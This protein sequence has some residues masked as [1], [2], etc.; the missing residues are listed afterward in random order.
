[1]NDNRLVIDIAYNLHDE[2]DRSLWREIGPMVI[3]VARKAI[4]EECL[5]A[6]TNPEWQEYQMLVLKQEDRLP[7]EYERDTADALLVRRRRA[8]L[9]PQEPTAQ[10]ISVSSDGFGRWRVF[11]DGECQV[12]SA[13]K[14]TC[15]IY[16]DGLRYR[17]QKEAAAPL[18]QDRVEAILAKT[19]PMWDVVEARQRLAAEIVA[20]LA[21]RREA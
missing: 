3:R 18:A 15:E 20:S 6:V 9:A 19:Y 21:E 11:A 16:A 2:E 4:T 7:T 1:M 10:E 13:N 5:G 12:R 17:L 14:G 8:R